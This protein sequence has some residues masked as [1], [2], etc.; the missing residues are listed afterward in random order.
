[1]LARDGG[2][3]TPGCINRAMSRLQMDHADPFP[4]GASDSANTG[5]L[6]ITC[7]QLKTA[8]Y[9]EIRQSRADGSCTWRTAWGQTV[10]VPPRSYLPGLDD[11]PPEPPPPVDPPPVSRRIRRLA[12]RGT[13]DLV[14][15][16]AVDPA[17]AWARR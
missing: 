9:V 2:C 1:M 10:R 4:E 13:G 12:G 17:V 16:H 7:H 5:G 8:G 15:A 3:R 14:L 6:C 11:P